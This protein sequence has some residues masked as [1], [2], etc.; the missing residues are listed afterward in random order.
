MPQDSGMYLV[1]TVTATLFIFIFKELKNLMY[2]NLYNM[3]TYRN[4]HACV[5]IYVITQ[6]TLGKKYST[7]K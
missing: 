1:Y 3:H 7:I 6:Q 4:L 2:P 5:P